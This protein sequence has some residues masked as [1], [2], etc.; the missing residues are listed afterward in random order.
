MPQ[1]HAL[2]QAEVERLH[3]HQPGHVCLGVGQQHVQQAQE[4]LP[5]FIWREEWIGQAIRL[6][7]AMW[8]NEESQKAEKGFRYSGFGKIT[9][10]AD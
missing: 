1:H 6:A 7:R 2:G 9:S 8:P 10:R 4:L 3:L 5:G